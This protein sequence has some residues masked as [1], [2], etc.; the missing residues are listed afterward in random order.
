MWTDL[1]DKNNNPNS[2]KITLAR[3]KIL[4]ATGWMLQSA[5]PAERLWNLVHGKTRYERLCHC[6][7]PLAWGY[8]S[9]GYETGKMHCSN[10]CWHVVR[11]AV[12]VRKVKTP[13]LTKDERVNRQVSSNMARYGAPWPWMSAD[14]KSRSG[15]ER[16]KRSVNK[17]FTQLSTRNLTPLFE[18]NDYLDEGSHGKLEVKCGCGTVFKIQRYKENSNP[19]LCPTCYTPN[20][21]RWQHEIN[22]LI[23]SWGVRT[24]L[25]DR[26]VLGGNYELDIYAPDQ[27]T[28]IECDGAWWHSE[29][30]RPDIMKSLEHKLELEQASGVRVFRIYD[31]EYAGRREIVLGRLRTAFGFATEKF[32]AREC[33]LVELS[34]KDSGVFF[35]KTH[36]Q[37]AGVGRAFGLEHNGTLLMAMSF[38]KPRW[39]QEDQ[40]L[41]RFS[42]IP[43]IIVRGGASKLFKHAVSALSAASIISYADLRFGNGS[44][45]GKLGFRDTGNT[46]LGYYFVRSSGEVASRYELQKKKMITLEGETAIAAAARLGWY[47]VWTPGH[48][49]WGW[50]APV[51]TL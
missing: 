5:S 40:E 3:D 33:S 22:D 16:K 1:L 41:I 39:S 15:F 29:A 51:P 26:T 28:A 19:G 46:G 49:R 42:C 12:A 20:A 13:H 32:N 7:Q 6:G 21:S 4:A 44:V 11:R 38:A 31:W 36:L 10:K 27:N 23:R 48:R 37:G 2:R 30:G 9:I 17:W 50:L 35:E 8:W 45:Y 18:I 43:G 34:S 24:R 14:I 47:R 25:N